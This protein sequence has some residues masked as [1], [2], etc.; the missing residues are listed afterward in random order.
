MMCFPDSEVATLLKKFLKYFA[1]NLLESLH[2]S[3]VIKNVNTFV[4]EMSTIFFFSVNA[5]SSS[6]SVNSSLVIKIIYIQSSF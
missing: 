3:E 5:S 6:Y 4:I 2:N 1:W